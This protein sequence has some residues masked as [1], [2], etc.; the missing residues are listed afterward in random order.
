[1]LYNTFIS[2]ASLPPELIVGSI[3]TLLNSQ[4]FTCEI[5]LYYYLNDFCFI[6]CIHLISQI[7]IALSLTII[8]LRLRRCIKHFQ[9]RELCS[10]YK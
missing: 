7:I 9:S 1:M 8:K 5:F 4:L 2:Q 3:S 6:E 10:R